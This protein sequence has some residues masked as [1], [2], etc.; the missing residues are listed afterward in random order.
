MTLLIRPSLT[1]LVVVVFEAILLFADVWPFV[2]ESNWH[3][4]LPYLN[5]AKSLIILSLSAFGRS[6]PTGRPR[7]V[8]FPTPVRRST[9][10]HPHM[11]TRPALPN[12]TPPELEYSA[13]FRPAR[14]SGQ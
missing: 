6:V 3:T 14:R 8:S 2:Q 11:L 5:V 12:T 1:K 4:E 9:H 7:A 10:I 13:T